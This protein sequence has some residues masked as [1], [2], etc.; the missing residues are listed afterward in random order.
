MTITRSTSQGKSSAKDKLIYRCSDDYGLILV[1]E[2]PRY[3]YLN[4]DSV[5]E[6]S[7]FNLARPYELVHEYTRIMLLVLGFVEPRHITLLGLGGGSLLR[8]LH[9]YLSHCDFTQIELRQAVINVAINYFDVPN[10]E[11]VTFIAEDALTAL[12]DRTCDSTDIIFSDIYDA[13]DMSS[14]QLAEAFLTQ[15]ERVLTKSGWLVINF[16]KL[17]DKHADF[18]VHLKSLFSCILIA[19]GEF[20]SHVLFAG[21]AHLPDLIN[22][23]ARATHLEQILGGN[24]ANL[25]ERVLVF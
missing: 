10:D 14:V 22:L 19:P 15:S 2:N 7:G 23:Q 12:K 13:A 17:P 5:F 4:F 16:H 25:V 18:F 3:R 6:Q 11:R 21:K 9:H 1:L 8:S 24:F 20:N